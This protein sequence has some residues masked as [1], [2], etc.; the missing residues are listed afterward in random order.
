M[1]L[2]A[3]TGLS[4]DVV[5]ETLDSDFVDSVTTDM[6][7]GMTAIIV[8]ANRAAHGPWTI[9]SRWAEAMSIGRL[10]ENQPKPVGRTAVRLPLEARILSPHTRLR[11]RHARAETPLRTNRSRTIGADASEVSADH[12]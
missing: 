9:S 1:A 8:E 11:L 12:R 3:T 7:P 10:P 5:M 2:G 4:G 6:R